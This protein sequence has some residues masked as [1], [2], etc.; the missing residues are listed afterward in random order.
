M[1]VVTVPETA[2]YIVHVDQNKQFFTCVFLFFF[3]FRKQLR[4][5]LDSVKLPCIPYLGMV[6]QYVIVVCN[7]KVPTTLEPAVVHFLCT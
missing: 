2:T 4:D 7:S 6:N 5:Y 1:H 3:F